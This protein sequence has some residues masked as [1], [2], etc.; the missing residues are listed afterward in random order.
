MLVFRFENFDVANFALEGR[1]PRTLSRLMTGFQNWFW[2]LWK[3]LIP[4]LPK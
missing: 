4:T 2:S 3:Y 1:F